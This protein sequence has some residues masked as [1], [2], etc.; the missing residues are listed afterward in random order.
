MKI[1]KVE[2]LKPAPY[3]PRAISDVQLAALGRA[4]RE[5]GDLGCVV[6]NRRTGH[7]VGGHMRLRNVDPN[8]VVDKKPAKDASGTVAVGSIAAP[9]GPV[10]YREVDWPESKEKAAN[11][12]ANKHGGVFD[13]T[14]VGKILADLKAENYDLDLTGFLAG[15][16]LAFDAGLTAVT[17]DDA[18]D[19][20][21][22]ATTKPGDLLTLGRHRILCG[23]ARDPEA[24]KKLMGGKKADAM[25]TDPPYGVEYVGKTKKKLTLNNDGAQGLPALLQGAFAAVS[26][27]A[28]ADGAALY[29][30]H[31]AGPLSLVFVQAFVAAKWR[32]HETLIWLKNSLVLGHSDYHYKH[33]P[34]LF[35]YKAG[36]GRRGRGGAGWYGP[37]NET[38]VLAYD[39]PARSEEHPTMKPVGL[40]AHCL[41]NSCPPGG[42]A[43]D[44]FLGS[45]TTLVAAEKLGQVCY[46]LELDPRYCDVIKKRFANLREGQDVK[47]S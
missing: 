4:M 37:N 38:S 32:L 26:D 41:R 1:S 16:L 35:G 33:E 10:K 21:A 12:A 20:P 44:P 30:A 3:N 14:A 25:W 15:D 47:E 43:V 6:F 45:G 19:V 17:E 24:W 2:D 31:P 28:L 27:V 29:V 23:D 34:L 18:P 40:V 42:L 13:L 39:R 9:G 8:A 22:S 36:G 46:G 5:F 7:L 11:L